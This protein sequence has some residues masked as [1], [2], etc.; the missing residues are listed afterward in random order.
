MKQNRDLLIKAL[1][2]VAA[3]IVIFSSLSRIMGSNSKTL[4]QYAEENPEIAYKQSEAS[5]VIEDSSMD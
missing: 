2:A 3:I 5:E 1:L 4:S